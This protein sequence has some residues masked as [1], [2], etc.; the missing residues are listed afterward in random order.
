MFSLAT[1]ADSISNKVSRRPTYTCTIIA[2]LTI[3]MNFLEN[4]N[5]TKYVKA[6]VKNNEHLR[7]NKTTLLN[8]EAWKLRCLRE[9]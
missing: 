8:V 7:S 5:N 3:I 2:F 6:K 1:P 9:D 4:S